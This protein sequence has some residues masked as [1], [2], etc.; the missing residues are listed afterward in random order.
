MKRI[1]ETVRQV[2]SGSGQTRQPDVHF[3]RRG[4]IT[5]VC[6][7]SDCRLPHLTAE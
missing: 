1:R 3:H 6:Y 2:L 4:A 7:D 5:E